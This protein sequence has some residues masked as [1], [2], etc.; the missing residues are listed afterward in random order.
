MIPGLPQLGAVELVILLCIILLFFG[1]NRV[2]GLARS[3]GGG[4]RE[5]RKGASGQYDEV[6]QKEEKWLP[7]KEKAGPEATPEAE[8]GVLAE[9]K[10]S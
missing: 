10:K 7:E 6:E 4:I 3:L 9:Q 8:G 2:P 5:F 1:A